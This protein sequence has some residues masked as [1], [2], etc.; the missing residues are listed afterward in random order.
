[1]ASVRHHSQ[2]TEEELSRLRQEFGEPI[3]RVTPPYHREIN[4]D[5][6]RHFAYGIGDDNPLWLD[7]EY[8]KGTRWGDLIAPPCILYSTDNIVS[9]AVHGFAG[10]HAMFAGTDWRWYGPIRRGTRIQ[11]VASLEDLIEHET[12]FAGRSIQQVYRVKFFN[13]KT[14]ELLADADSWCFRTE[15][16]TARESGTKYQPKE[17]E[18]PHYTREDMERITQAYVNEEVRGATPR[19]W[20]DVQVGDQLPPIL[21]GPYTV[22]SVVVW[23]QTWGNYA[24]HA[25]KIAHKYYHQHPGLAITNEFGA[26]EPPV[27]VHW[28]HEF[29]REV[30]VPRAYDYGPERISW[31]GNLMT[32]WIGD[33]GSLSRLNILIRRHNPIGDLTT[34]KGTVTGKRLDGGKGI[35]TCDLWTENQDGLVTSQGS[36]EAQLPRKG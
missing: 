15:R 27:R 5:A 34:C 3:T 36:A 20:E 17:R 1:M 35:V 29:A 7:E 30:G 31:L 10:V 11:S 19:H 14:G 16:D 13:E 9:G 6:I 26:Y 8:A 24:V 2:I 23:M 12:S 33:D 4:D 32:N 21:K 28:D 22:T 25:H 18:F